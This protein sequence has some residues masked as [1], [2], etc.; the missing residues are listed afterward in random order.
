MTPQA[1]GAPPAIFA[2]ASPPLLSLR[3]IRFRHAGAFARDGTSRGPGEVL[4]GVDLDVLPGEVV[5]LVGPNASGKSTLA[6]VGCGLLPLQEGEA[7]LGPDPVPGLSRRARARRVAFLAQHH[8]ADLPFT[9][10]EVALMGRAPHLGLWSLE[11][12]GD[13]A[14]ALAALDEVDAGELADRPISRLS[15]GERQRVFL[16]CALAQEAQLLVLDEP[17]AS[18]DLRHQVL[19]ANAVRRRARAGGGALLVLHDLVIAAGACDRLA[20]LVQGRIAAQGSP[21]QVLVPE[22]L[23][24]A[25]GTRV[26]VVADPATGVPLV[27]AR[28]E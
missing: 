1:P 4:H 26:D 22:V 28:L 20:L 15:G 10:L 27:A 9:A 2:K 24:R 16:A 25:Y 12:P 7:R 14:L 5:G 23:A 17:T 18:L 13:R 3:G 21:A 6:K 19:L 11:G 8:P